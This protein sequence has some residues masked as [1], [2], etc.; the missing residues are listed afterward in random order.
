MTD[1]AFIDTVH[2]KKLSVIERRK[3]GSKVYRIEFR[4]RVIFDHQSKVRAAIVT[5]FKNLTDAI[6]VVSNEKM[7]HD[8]RDAI[9]LKLA[10]LRT[11]K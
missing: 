4:D 7:L 2:V 3:D 9:D 11:K 1:I 10:V 8:M 6:D 5:V